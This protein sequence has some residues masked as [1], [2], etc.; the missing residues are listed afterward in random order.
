[1]NM[2][3][4]PTYIYH[5]LQ[6]RKVPVEL[7]DEKAWLMRYE[8]D[9]TWHYLKG[10]LTDE[11]GV[12]SC[13]ICDNKRL[14]ERF[15]REAGMDVPASVRYE[16]DEQTMA[17]IERYGPIAVKPLNAAHG[18]GISLNVASVTAVK[19]A[20]VSARQYSSVPP[21]LQQMVSGED[22]RMLLIGG[23]Y[24]AAVRRVPAMVVGDGM[25][26]IKQ[27]IEMENAKPHRAAGKRGELKIISLD[28]AKAYLK[29]RIH[30]IP[31]TGE[32]V[33]VVGVSNT[34]MGGHAEDA[35][36][37]V[38]MEIR[39]KAAAFVQALKLPVCGIDIIRAPTG[40]C[41][42][43]EANASPGFGPHHHPRVGQK[44]D[45][46]KLFVDFLL[47]GRIPKDGA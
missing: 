43:I 7:I 19:K 6:R 24:V 8:K 29:K 34:S 37:E 11:T 27:L 14:A 23:V 25:H 18:H 38:P 13:G 35:T 15:A 47:S 4:T 30:R 22:I 12:I 33:A 39:Q 42:F 36:D 41:K 46:T 26:T 2:A 3:N 16:N 10:C 5:E 17:F 45:V 28:G 44:R 32:Q 31:P 20:V 1:M 40:R 9:G 21:I